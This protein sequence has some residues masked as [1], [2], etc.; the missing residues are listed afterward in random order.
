MTRHIQTD[1]NE[2]VWTE[3]DEQLAWEDSERILWEGPFAPGNSMFAAVHHSTRE[4]I[5]FDILT[6]TLDDI[7]IGCGFLEE[8]REYQAQIAREHARD[9]LKYHTGPE[10]TVPL[11]T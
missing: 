1:T 7:M 5:W 10:T 2:I 8:H 11:L 6:V 9:F 4:F 3:E